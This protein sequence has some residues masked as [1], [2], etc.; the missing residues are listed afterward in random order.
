M[1]T[2]KG[3]YAEAKIFIDHTEPGL[4]EQVQR[5]LDNL[6]SDGQKIRIMPDCHVGN[7]ICIGYVS[8]FSDKIIPSF[9]GVDLFCGMLVQKL[10][11]KNIDFEKLDKILHNYVPSG[12]SIHN[13]PHRFSNLI[14]LT[15]LKCYPYLKNYKKFELA[16][17]TIGNGNHFFE[18]DKDDEG[19]YYSVI[20]TG[21]RNLGK[22]V[23][24]YYQQKAYESLVNNNKEKNNLI[25]KL[26]AEGN[27]QNIQKELLKIEKM[28][29]NKNMAYCEGELMKDYLYDM[30]ICKQYAELNRKAIADIIQRGMNWKIVEEFETLHNYVD[31]ENKI[32]RKGAVSAKKG[33][34]LIIPISPAFG[35]L[36]C[37]GKG[38]KDYN[39]SA[40]HGG[41]R[42]M[43]RKAA[44]EKYTTKDFEDAM[45]GIYTTT[46]SSDTVDECPM[47]Y[48]DPK[49]IIENIKD[50]VDI[51]KHII[52]VYN[53]K[54]FEKN[55]FKKQ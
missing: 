53:F 19:N 50:T 28:H 12:F 45:S 2:I 23:A 46:I 8:T 18:I 29:I 7:G 14:D 11:N 43:S 42:A 3:K 31:I 54:G 51:I 49:E 20:H 30:A 36:I 48:K 40:P 38:N 34:I 17:G 22:Q 24:D 44:K 37:I 32:L 26:K 41:G 10:E 47:A 5:V 39:Y 21:S 6:I 13:R 4:I 16:I 9:V 15:K 35:S 52:P 27:E 55:N 33:E 1:M 25:S